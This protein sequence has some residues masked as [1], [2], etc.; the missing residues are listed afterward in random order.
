MSDEKELVTNLATDV[1]KDTI[2]VLYNK[3]KKFFNDLDV[4]NAIRYKTAYEEYIS[5]TKQKN[6][7]IKTL[8]SK[9]V[10]NDLNSLYVDIDVLYNGKIINTNDICNL[11]KIGN[12]IIVTGIGGT[13]KT[14]LFK[15]LFFNTIENTGLIPVLLKLRDFN[16]CELSNISIYNSIYNSLCDNGFNLNMEHF[17]YSMNEGCYIIFFDAF[18]EINT[19]KRAKITNEIQKISEEY[20]NNIYFLSSR[21]SEEF[22]GWNDF[23]EIKIMELTEGQISD[24]VKKVEITE[25]TRKTF[26]KKLNNPLYEKYKLFAKNPLLLNIMLLAFQEYNESENQE[27]TTPENLNEFYNI[28]FTYLYYKHDETKEFYTRNIKSG[29]NYEDFKLVFSYICFKSYFSNKSQFSET[30]LRQYIH[31]AKEKLNMYDFSIENFQRDLTQSVCMLVKDGLKYSF[32]YRS[33][34]EYFAAWYTCKLLDKDQNEL[35]LCWIKESYSIFNDSYFTVL[36]D[37]QSEKV[38]RIIIYPILKEVQQLYIKHGF[39][40]KL[41]ETLFTGIFITMKQKQYNISLGVKNKY[42]CCG[43]WLNTKL[44]R[45]LYEE[46]NTSEMFKKLQEIFPILLDDNFSGI[47]QIS[48]DE[49]LTVMT[50]DEILNNLGYIQQIEFALQ[51]IEKYESNIKNKIVADILK[52]L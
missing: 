10:P 44:N 21:P 38:N 2:K 11:I 26:Y 8:I 29:L 35:L 12:K 6:C 7:K 4:K 27:H 1:A 19:D 16:D 13:G 51:T 30:E 39:S 14:F 37:L 50:E 36:F 9:Y 24:M 41:L 40:V 17:D 32:S 45:F 28:A 20:N 52:E 18:D 34:Q 22:I 46:K 42:L 3:I 49:L 47:L 25:L 48:F 43:I 33:F 15:H 5:N 31:N 23:C